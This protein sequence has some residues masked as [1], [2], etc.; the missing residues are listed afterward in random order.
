MCN[1][2]TG[3]GVNGNIFLQAVA[4]TSHRKSTDANTYKNSKEDFSVSIDDDRSNEI[5]KKLRREKNW[6]RN[7][8]VASVKKE[9]MREL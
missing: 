3:S 1:I 7:E 2:K 8:K 6:K 4:G 5:V 9:S